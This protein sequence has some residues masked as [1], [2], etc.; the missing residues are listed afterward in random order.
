MAQQIN[1][2][3]PIQLAHKQSFSAKTMAQALGVFVVFGGVL[4]AA[5]VWNL[6][7]TSAGFAQTVESQGRDIDN[8]K[9][10]LTAARANTAPLGPAMLAQLQAKRTE[11]AQREQLLLAAQ[12]GVLRPGMGH[13]DRLALVARS[14]PQPVWVGGIKADSTR[15]E[16]S[17]FTLEPAALNEWVAR[18]SASPMLS[19]LKLANVQVE[20]TAQNAAPVG[21]AVPVS[22]GR[23][24]WSFNLVSEQAGPAANA[25]ANAGGKP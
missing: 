8:L 25:N 20:N 24:V 19:G 16:V 3:S 22:G 7:K 12:E 11:L 2:C 15:F 13:S 9:N 1:L 6:H 17:G 14:I 10:A 23:P 4:C 18:L 5:F 21:V